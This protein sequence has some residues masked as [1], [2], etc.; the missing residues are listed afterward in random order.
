MVAENCPDCRYSLSSFAPHHGVL[1]GIGGLDQA[2]E[3]EGHI[4]EIDFLVVTARVVVMTPNGEPGPPHPLAE[5]Q[6]VAL[7]HRAIGI[8]SSQK[9]PRPH[10]PGIEDAA[11]HAEASRPNGVHALQPLAGDVL[12]VGVRRGVVIVSVPIQWPFAGQTCPMPD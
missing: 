6:V 3:R 12:S 5:R 8:E 7:I 1:P 2:L 9:R 10:L 4:M 11:G